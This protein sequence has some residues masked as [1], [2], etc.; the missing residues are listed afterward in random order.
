MFLA[1]CSPPFGRQHYRFLGII[2]FMLPASFIAWMIYAT[3]G[4]RLALLCRV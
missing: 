3:D 2:L 1:L 4:R